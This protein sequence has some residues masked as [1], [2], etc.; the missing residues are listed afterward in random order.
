LGW[1]IATIA[2][3]GK[4]GFIAPVMQRRGSSMVNTTP[5]V[6]GDDFRAGESKQTPMK[7]K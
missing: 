7:A 2:E 1:V 3:K 4:V 5:K 6:K